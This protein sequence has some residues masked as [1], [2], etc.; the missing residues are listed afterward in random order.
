[1]RGLTKRSEVAFDKLCLE[2]CREGTGRKGFWTLEKQL[3]DDWVTKV[4]RWAFLAGGE[5]HSDRD[6]LVA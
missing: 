1:M 6:T 2:R 5:S 4:Q 3:R